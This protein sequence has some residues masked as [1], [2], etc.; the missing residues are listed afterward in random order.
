M[1]AAAG[2]AI[3]AEMLLRALTRDSGA[4]A[5]LAERIQDL[6]DT[7]RD[8][9]SGEMYT[10]VAHGVRGLKGARLALRVRA[11]RTARMQ[12]LE[13]R[14]TAMRPAWVY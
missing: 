11:A 6:A 2:P 1:A 13:P 12:R 10:M 3:L 14:A 8:Q 7:L 9:L 5:Y 4:L